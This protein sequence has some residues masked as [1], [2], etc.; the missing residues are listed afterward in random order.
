M[1]AGRGGGGRRG[2]SRLPK[3]GS[4]GCSGR[5]DCVRMAERPDIAKW[6]VGLEIQVGPGCGGPRVSGKICPYPSGNGHSKAQSGL[7]TLNMGVTGHTVG[8]IGWRERGQ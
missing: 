4:T 1:R 2:G 5:G 3:V 7:A 6:Q 8:L